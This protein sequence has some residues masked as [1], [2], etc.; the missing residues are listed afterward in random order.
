[1]RDYTRKSHKST[2]DATEF[3]AMRHRKKISL[4][5]SISF[6]AAINP[7]YERSA[8]R[9]PDDENPQI[10]KM[11]FNKTSRALASLFRLRHHMS[12][13]GSFSFIR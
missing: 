11:F 13:E 5:E 12:T 10:L 7:R 9:S 2:A 4:L 1:M 8:N 6:M 3:T